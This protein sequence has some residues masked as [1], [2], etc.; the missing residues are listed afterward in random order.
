MSDSS[1]KNNSVETLRREYRGEVLDKEKVQA[2][3]VDQFSRWFEEALDSDINDPNAMT[4]ATAD[5]SGKPSARIVLLKG[6]D[7]GGFRFYTNYNSRKGRELKENPEAALCF[8]WPELDRQ[9][10]IEGMVEPIDRKESE[11][12]FRIRPRESQIA[13]WASNQSS[14]LEDRSELEERFRQI[15]EKFENEEVPLPE[16][17]GGYQLVPH[18]VEFWQGRPGRLHDRIQYTR[19]GDTWKIKRLSP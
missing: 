3:P 18:T 2:D 8:Y 16:F 7:E 6:F 13:A 5:A 12:Y 15:R 14:E 9:V 4:L 19:D 1:I 11:K 17:W 10:R